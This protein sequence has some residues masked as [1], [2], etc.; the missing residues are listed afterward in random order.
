MEVV[1]GLSFA[2]ATKVSREGGAERAARWAENFTP[3]VRVDTVQVISRDGNGG[4]DRSEPWVEG[5][6]RVEIP[7]AG[8]LAPTLLTCVAEDTDVG[9]LFSIPDCGAASDEPAV[10][11]ALTPTYLVENLRLDPVTEQPITW[12]ATLP[13]LEPGR[14]A[15]IRF[16][17]RAQTMGAA[18]RITPLR[19]FGRMIDSEQRQ[20]TLELDNVGGEAITVTDVDLVPNMG[21]PQDFG[22]RVVGDPIPMPLP[23]EVPVGGGP[24]RLGDLAEV[25]LLAVTELDGGAVEVSLGDPQAAVTTD[26]PFTLYGE[27]VTLRGGVL[28]RDEAD[29]VFAPAEE[30]DPRPFVLPAYVEESPPFV[31]APGARRLVVIETRPTADGQRTAYL[32]VRGTPA[33]NP[34]Q[35]L[36]VRSALTMEVVSGPLLRWAPGSLLISRRQGGGEPTHR[37]AV[38]FNAG[39]ADLEVLDLQLAGPGALRFA[40]GT[41][42]G[43]LGPFTLAPGDYVDV[44]VEYQP[45]CDGTYGTATSSIDHAATLE[46]STNDGVGVLEV[47]GASYGFCEG[48]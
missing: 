32:R 37:T 24:W 46:V 40:V 28:M 47:A 12:R 39:H 15:F 33:N 38:L 34:Q 23:V 48:P 1:S 29:A 16:G 11:G 10:L 14:Q 35:L 26:Q 45:E 5:R 17:V 6:L 22:F 44:T 9:P 19:D 42:R 8:A 20:A 31:L 41:D 3:T 2:W 36:E 4:D 30:G 7:R 18:L 43:S 25:P 21:Q 27:G 13:A